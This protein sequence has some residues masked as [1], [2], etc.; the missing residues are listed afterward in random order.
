LYQDRSKLSK[1]EKRQQRRWSLFSKEELF[2]PAEG[3]IVILL[4][5]FGRPGAVQSG[6]CLSLLWRNIQDS[7]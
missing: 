5:F 3:F 4:L 7:T 1:K 6:S 2:R